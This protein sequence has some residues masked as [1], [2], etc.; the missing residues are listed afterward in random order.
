SFLAYAFS[1]NLGFGGLT[2]G[3]VRYRFY[4]A[5]GASPLDVAKVILF[6]GAAYFLGAF[7]VAGAPVQFSADA[8]GE[9][10]GLPVWLVHAIGVA[11]MVAG[12]FY[13]I[14]SARG[15]P[16]IR[17]AGAVFPPPRLRLCLAQL[18]VGCLEWGF[19][20]AALFWLLPL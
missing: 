10:V 3:A 7:A 5:W 20:S 17:A 6:G 8:L 13:I 1:H 4:T 2:G 11:W 19:A 9:V 15:R 14:W 12:C 18:S 16:T